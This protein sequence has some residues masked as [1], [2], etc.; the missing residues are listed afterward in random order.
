M[1]SSWLLHWA[2]DCSSFILLILHISSMRFSRSGRQTWRQAEDR[3]QRSCQI[4]FGSSWKAMAR[5]SKRATEEQHFGLRYCIYRLLWCLPSSRFWQLL[6]SI[7]W[8]SE[9]RERDKY[10][11]RNRNHWDPLEFD[12]DVFKSASITFE[13]LQACRSIV[14]FLYLPQAGNWFFS[15]RRQMPLH[16][17]WYLPVI[18]QYT[19]CFGLIC[20]AITDP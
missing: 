12:R 2:Y 11:G 15:R 19:K 4:R 18:N 7:E 6:F 8:C 13:V 16:L 17:P 9:Q 10:E 20:L 14:L 5:L 1:L 3:L